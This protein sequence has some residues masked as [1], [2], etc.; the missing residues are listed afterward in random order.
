MRKREESQRESPQLSFCAFFLLAILAS[1][2]FSSRIFRESTDD[3]TIQRG[4]SHTSGTVDF[5]RGLDGPGLAAGFDP[6]A[7]ANRWTPPTGLGDELASSSARISSAGDRFFDGAAGLRTN[8]AAC[9]GA[10][11][12]VFAQ[13]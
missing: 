12:G 10:L 9:L 1:W 5:V 2:R 4:S 11:D 13:P 8:L 7:T 3:P 6:F